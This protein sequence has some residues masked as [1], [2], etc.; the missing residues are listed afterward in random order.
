MTDGYVDSELNEQATGE[1]LPEIEIPQPTVEEIPAP[2]IRELNTQQGLLDLRP[3]RSFVSTVVLFAL[4][5]LGLGVMI[6]V[7]FLLG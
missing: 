5:G 1:L 4:I 6:G 7:G 3:K 2:P